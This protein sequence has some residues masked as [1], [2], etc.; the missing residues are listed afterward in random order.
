MP[1]TLA[2]VLRHFGPQYLREHELS[3]QQ[4]RAWRDI[5]SCRSGALGGQRLQCDSCGH[6]RWQYHS[7]R[8]RACPQCQTRQREA[9]H[10]QNQDDGA[11][12]R[13]SGPAVERFSL[14]LVPSPRGSVRNPPAAQASASVTTPSAMHTAR[15]S[16]SVRSRSQ[17]SWPP[18]TAA[19]S[20]ESS[21]AGATCDSG[22]S[23]T[24]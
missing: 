18:S 11:T 1:L 15:A 2:D 20:I 14:K 10:A 3:A 8:H 12:P 16:R 23:V 17:S 21:R 4:A 19:N 6:T 22:A 24:A 5:L 9:W 7:C 13:S